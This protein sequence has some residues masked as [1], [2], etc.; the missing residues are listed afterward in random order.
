MKTKSKTTWSKLSKLKD[1]EINLSD[2]PEL[3]ID[4]FRK[5]EIKMPKPKKMVSIRLDEDVLFWFRKQV[6]GYQTKINQVL[7]TYMKA[8]V[9]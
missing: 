3:G 5:A 6:K 8:K 2:I 1:K 4:F 9:A 7:K